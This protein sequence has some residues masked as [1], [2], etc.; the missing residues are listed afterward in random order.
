MMFLH[1]AAK[2]KAQRIKVQ[3]WLILLLRVL[4]FVLLA[5]ALA[6][7]I[8]KRTEMASSDQPI[9]HMVVIDGSYSM[10]R[11]GK[12]GSLFNK[13]KQRLLEIVEQMKRGDNMGVIWASHH[14]S[15]VFDGLSY[16]REYLKRKSS[17]WSQAHQKLT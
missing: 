3:Q 9:T 6:R 13:A 14:P 12:H 15:F 11:E 1:S 10:Q 5:M 4:F 17:H 16:D 2:A 8:I 7:P